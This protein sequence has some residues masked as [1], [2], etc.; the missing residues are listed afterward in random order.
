MTCTRHFQEDIY[1]KNQVDSG[2]TVRTVDKIKEII[3]NKNKVIASMR[4]KV[5]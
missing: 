5:A 4:E 3:A 1:G 2:S